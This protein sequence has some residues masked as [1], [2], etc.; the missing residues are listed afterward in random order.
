[1]AWP[2]DDARAADASF[3]ETPLEP[4]E[5][6]RRVEESVVVTSFIV[7]AVIRC[8]EDDGVLLQLQQLEKIQNGTHILILDR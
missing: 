4:A 3:I 5:R 1:M 7:R 2:F 6:P 8:K